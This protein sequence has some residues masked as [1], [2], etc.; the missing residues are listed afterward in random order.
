MP[1]VVAEERAVQAVFIYMLVQAPF[2]QRYRIGC[3]G[4][5]YRD[6]MGR[7]YPDRIRSGDLLR[8][9]SQRFS[10]VEIDMTFY[11]FPSAKAVKA[12]YERTPH[13]FLFSAKMNRLITHYRKLKGV[14]DS[15]GSFLDVMSG[16][17]EKL[18]PLLV[19]LPPDLAPDH[20]LLEGFLALLPEGYRY[21]VEFRDPGWLGTRTYRLLE[22]YGMALCLVDSSRARIEGPAT[23]SFAYVRWHG[24]G[25]AAYD[26]GPAELEEAA[27]ALRELPVNEVFG[28]FNNDVGAHAPFNAMAMDERLAVKGKVPEVR[29]R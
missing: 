3:S 20:A 27:E 24:R 12:W 18:G 13:D 29:A 22:K 25:S 19:Q 23:A 1:T 26:Y 2:V 28:Y 21:A 8:F 4:W 17:E 6:W 10:T 9:Y 16:L 7:F 5:S 15:L 14:E 11:R